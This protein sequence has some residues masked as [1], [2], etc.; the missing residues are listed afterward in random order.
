[1][2]ACDLAEGNIRL[3]QFSQQSVVKFAFLFF[4]LFVCK[5][6]KSQLTQLDWILIPI[7]ILISRAG[8]QCHLA[9]SVLRLLYAREYRQIH[10][11]N[12]FGTGISTICRTRSGRVAFHRSFDCFSELGGDSCGHKPESGSLSIIAHKPFAHGQTFDE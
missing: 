11:V 7:P 12:K 6:S 3:T 4:A 9:G 8:A 5:Q 1:V 2:G 10:C